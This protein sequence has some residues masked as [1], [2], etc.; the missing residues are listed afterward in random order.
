M[1]RHS[2]QAMVES[3][4]LALA[5]ALALLLPVGSGRPVASVLLEAIVGYLRA[6]AYVL[7][8]V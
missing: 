3:L 5:L 6:Q 7:S 8:I 1:N 2:G 4:A